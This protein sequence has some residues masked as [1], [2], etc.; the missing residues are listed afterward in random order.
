MNKIIQRVELRFTHSTN[1]YIVCIMVQPLH[2]GQIEF[3]V[4]KE[5]FINLNS[6]QIKNIFVA[7]CYR[8]NILELL[9]I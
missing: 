2:R 9:I 3:S 6:Y 7:F 5:A 1:V 4:E 8:M